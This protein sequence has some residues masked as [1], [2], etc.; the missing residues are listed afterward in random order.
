MRLP[1]RLQLAH[2]AF[3]VLAV[4]MLVL[5]VVLLVAGVF[6]ANVPLRTD[7]AFS[8]GGVGSPTVQDF[9]PAETTDD[10]R[11]FRWTNGDSTLTLPPQ[12]FGAHS[13]RLTLSAP[14]P[15]PDPA[16]VP[17]TISINGRTVLQTTLS[18]TPRRYAFP[19][20]ADQARL[21]NTTVRIQSPTFRPDEVNRTVRD[22]GV[23]V[24]DVT[25]NG[26]DNRGGLVAAQIL[27]IS[28]TTSLF[29]LL[30]TRMG[31][32][33]WLRL[34]AVLLFVAITLAMRA[35]DMRFVYRWH[36][37]LMT[38]AT[39]GLLAGALAVT[40]RHPAG[41]AR[42]VPV[43][44]WIGLHW[45][46]FAAYVLV[47]CVML[48]PLIARFPTHII[49]LPGDNYEYL[50]KMDW[51]RAALL[52]EHVSPVFAPQIFYPSGSDL[53]VS[54][55]APAH[56]LLG[57]P[58]TWLFGPIV[59]YNLVMVTTFILTA[60]CT[61][62]L[63]RRLG[64]SRTAAW[65]A[66]I[67]F[68][69]CLRRY[70]HATGHFGMMGTQWLPLA[71]YGWEGVLTR[72]RAWDGYVAGMG[73]VLAAWS[74]LIYGATLPLFLAIYTLVRVGPRR[75][76][77]LW[78]AWRPILLAGVLA[79]VLV[80]PL[81][82]PYFEAQQEGRT[83]QH[84]YEQIILHAAVPEAYLLPNPFHPLWGDWAS[85]FY[86]TDGSEQYVALGYTTTLL[87][88]VGLWLGRKRRVVQ[89]LGVLVAVFALLSLGPELRLPNG[90]SL[91]LPARLMYE[92]VPVFG[93][94]R[95]WARMAIYV[96][97]CAA[98]LAGLA[99]TAVPGRWNRAAWVVAA[100]LIL[101]ESVSVLPLSSP[102]P[103][104]VDLW[105]RNQPGSGA[106]AH[107][108]H[109]SGEPREYYTLL[110]SGKPV[111]QGHGKFPPSH[112]REARNILFRFPDESVFR[113][114]QRWQ[115]GYFVVDEAAMQ[116][117]RP[118]WRAELAAQPLATE[119]YRVGGYSVYRM[120]N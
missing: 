106:V 30:L 83:F 36:A 46:A 89:A 10:G 25:W 84:L 87:A 112:Y 81:A 99:L 116:R 41:A 61:Y 76:P 15:A 64:A 103:R 73:Y 57:V 51:F 93:N 75:L 96:A 110:Y 54:E 59:G 95:T 91:P 50:W 69:F 102:Q 24:F 49:G 1:R 68:A 23:V 18:D 98:A 120:E 44:A 13:L 104:P 94:I 109:G 53:T 55:I 33:T 5:G 8:L 107:F 82:Q 6:L 88:L 66:G 34:P 115:T 9:H 2:T 4:D 118:D 42:L 35:S 97:L 16:G 45:R 47:T 108:P 14:W 85:R 20:T 31:V 7:T 90:G 17:V 105:L 72:R 37:L 86:R 117:E 92:H 3:R 22:L 58:A 70:F 62:L 19:V 56:H 11:G 40:W 27:A 80:L 67:I 39:G 114:M 48:F 29:Y 78:H 12:G 43:R 60:F 100:A 113:L 38:L 52:E 28:I 101:V 119:V 79:I 77:D 21:G 32:S 74:T 26:P 65:V 63:A 111:I 71:L